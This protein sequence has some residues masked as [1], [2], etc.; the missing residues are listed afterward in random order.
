MIRA[1][2]F[3]ICLR[4][5]QKIKGIYRHYLWM[6]YLRNNFISLGKNVFIGDG[7]RFIKE[8]IEVGDDVFIGEGA[9]F[10]SSIS[11]I[12]IGSHVMIAPNVT[13]RGGDHRLDIVGRYIKSIGDNEKLPENDQD[14]YIEDDV[15]IGCNV[16]ILKGVRVGRG[17]VIGAGSIVVKDIPPY[18][19]HV[20]CPGVKEFRR[21]TD[22]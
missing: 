11:T 3:E 15:W 13:I 6:P 10:I 16:T 20:G 14:V 8:H 7:F 1:M 9:N 17:S 12:H 5:C 2:I 18:T 4:M 22:E 21:F 19:I